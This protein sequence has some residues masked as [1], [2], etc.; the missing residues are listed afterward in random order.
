M[1]DKA[2][3]LQSIHS[4]I[5]DVF[6]VAQRP[7]SPLELVDEHVGAAGIQ[8]VRLPAEYFQIVDNNSSAFNRVDAQLSRTF[9]PTGSLMR[10]EII[11]HQDQPRGQFLPGEYRIVLEH[12]RLLR[13]VLPL[14]FGGKRQLKQSDTAAKN[15]L[16]ICNEKYA[17][18]LSIRMQRLAA[19]CIRA[20]S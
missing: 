17:H 12:G 9:S 2:E 14:P 7:N 11:C 20:S 4:S 15:G 8:A 13:S 1:F 19:I 18:N 10:E 3:S 5:D 6:R 16:I